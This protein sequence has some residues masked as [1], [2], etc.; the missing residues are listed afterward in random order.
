MHRAR[1]I[2]GVIL[3]WDSLSGTLHPRRWTR[4]RLVI[5]RRRLLVLSARAGARLD[6]LIG[7]T[8]TERVGLTDQP[9]Q[10]GQR[11]ALGLGRCAL[12]IVAIMVIIGGKRS[13]L[14][15][16]SHRDDASPSGKPPTR[17]YKR[18][19]RCQLAAPQIPMRAQKPLTYRISSGAWTPRT[20]SPD[21]RTE[22]TPW[23]KANRAFVISA[24]LLIMKR[25]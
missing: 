17:P 19:S 18:T 21:A 22:T 14:I 25:K 10:F 23:T 15:S 20:A 5:R 7:P 9:R 1:V 6:L 16:I 8:H 12:L 24:S 11:I 13:V 3:L 2:L 4:G